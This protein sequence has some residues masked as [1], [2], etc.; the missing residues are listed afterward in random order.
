MSDCV[1]TFDKLEVKMRKL[2]YERYEATN[3][4]KK[5]EDREGTVAGDQVRGLQEE[6]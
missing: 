5:Q 6:D 4:V 2:Q 3:E 1:D